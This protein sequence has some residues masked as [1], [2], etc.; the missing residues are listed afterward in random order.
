M[1]GLICAPECPY[2]THG[3]AGPVTAHPNSQSNI[4]SS[5]VITDGNALIASCASGC[6]S[7]TQ[8]AVNR[9]EVPMPDIS[10]IN[11]FYVHR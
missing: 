4:R 8:S 10:V 1:P 7:A 11:E 5:A 3:H 2:T 9:G 6:A